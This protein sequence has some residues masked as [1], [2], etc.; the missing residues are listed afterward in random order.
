MSQR[1]RTGLL[2]VAVLA[3]AGI[4]L[5]AGLIQLGER[6]MHADEAVNAIKLGKLLEGEG[7]R[8]NPEEYHGPTLPYL[9]AAVMFVQGKDSLQALTAGDL[10][11][12]TLLCGAGLIL[13]LPLVRGGLGTGGMLAA[14]VWTILCPA[15]SYYAR[16]YIHEILLVLFTFLAIAAGWRYVINP[17]LGWMILLGAAVGLMWATK[18]TFIFPMG[19][20]VLGLAVNWWW[21]RRERP[22]ASSD[23]PG[24]GGALPLASTESPEAPPSPDQ[25]D[26]PTASPDTPNASPATK[27]APKNHRSLAEMSRGRLL[28]HLLLAV[29]LALAVGVIF[30]SSFLTHWG[31]AGDAVMTYVHYLDRGL[32]EG[33]AANVH[34]HPWWWYFRLIGWHPLPPVLVWT[35]LLI[36]ALAG[37]G[38]VGGFVPRLLGPGDPRLARFLAVYSLGLL[39]LYSAV[40]YKTPWLM[41]GPLH[42]FV[43]LA[44]M[45]TAMLL[46]LGAVQLKE[47]DWPRLDATLAW[48]LPALLLSLSLLVLGG[49]QLARQTR[50]INGYFAAD[51]RNPFAYAQTAQ[52]V[53][54]LVERVRD[55]AEHHPKGKSMQVHVVAMHPWPLPWY[56]RD[57]DNVIFWDDQA[58]L[59][60]MPETLPAV[61]V[62]LAHQDL[63]GA[64]KQRLPRDDYESSYYGLRPGT[65][66][67]LNVH[68]TL[69]QRFM[70]ER[71]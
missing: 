43:L 64:I 32:G 13:L 55:L 16:D 12:V 36:L 8:Y 61:P 19:A 38:A 63:A 22:S 60:Q 7:Y 54:N 59:Q 50:F 21:P 48:R 6:P 46:R 41:I 25:A 39:L 49:G 71:R 34:V 69:W 52:D 68:P 66:L 57:F 28:S 18:E 70:N 65:K 3:L 4:G 14:A 17:R 24:Q 67:V 45:G 42:G 30:Y 27:A 33:E 15:L 37:V 40:P 11:L 26:Q 31:G 2:L 62:A 5:G 9:S 51:A 53:E 10:R 20:M 23:Q 35:H 1:M 29:L 58:R 44:G 56:L 47:L